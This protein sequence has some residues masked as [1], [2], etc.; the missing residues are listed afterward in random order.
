MSGSKK[1]DYK[2]YLLHECINVG[3]RVIKVNVHTL[4]VLKQTTT[5]VCY[6]DLVSK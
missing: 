3:N 2:F 4:R 5:V 6:I 1:K